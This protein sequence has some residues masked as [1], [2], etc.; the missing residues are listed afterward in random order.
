MCICVLVCLYVCV[1][2]SL[3]DLFTSNL[4]LTSFEP[5]TYRAFSYSI[6]GSHNSPP[7]YYPFRSP[8]NQA[9]LGL[10]KRS[11]TNPDYVV[12]HSSLSCA[13][14]R[15]ISKAGLIPKGAST[16]RTTAPGLYVGNFIARGWPKRGQGWS[17]IRN[18][19]PYT[20]DLAAPSDGWFWGR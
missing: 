14:T 20:V 7:L 19:K 3:I 17:I 13:C 8:L 16:K 9:C 18:P 10:I 15:S 5:T 11:L 1:S 4:T 2:A 12:P 6:H